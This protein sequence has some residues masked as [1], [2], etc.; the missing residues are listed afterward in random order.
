MRQLFVVRHGQAS[1]LRTNY[2]D[3]SELGREQATALGEC[4]V[5]QGWKLDLVYSGSAVRHRDTARR[6]GKAM[7]AAGRAWPV[8]MELAGLDEVDELSL[9]RATVGSLG[10]DE[11]IARLRREML[12]VRERE[13]RSRRFQ[14]LFE[15]V[16][17]RWLRGDFEPQGVETWPQFRAR[18]LSCVETMTSLCEPE[19]RIL[20]FTS[21]GPLAVLLQRALGIDDEA[22][23]GMAWRVRN[24]AIT[25]LHFDA[26]GRLA[27]DMFNTLPHLRDPQQWTLH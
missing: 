23:F 21:V 10:D 25:S 27:L 7:E 9:V 19:T 13:E 4:F 26:R 17:I 20:A 22:A 6:V 24:T 12:D 15:A 11:E 1:L 16:M 3:L 14:R 5:E 8:P 18:V 2:D